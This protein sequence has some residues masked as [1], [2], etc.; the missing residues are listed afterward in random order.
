MENVRKNGKQLVQEC[1]SIINTFRYYAVKPL[2]EDALVHVHAYTSKAT[3]FTNM[4][5]L[6]SSVSACVMETSFSTKEMSKRS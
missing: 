5:P 6:T 2:R 4:V 3:A 1:V